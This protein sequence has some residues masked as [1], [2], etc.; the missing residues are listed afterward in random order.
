MDNVNTKH[1]YVCL[2]QHMHLEAIF[3]H[4]LR[5]RTQRLLLQL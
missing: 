3:P 2:I 4:T 1:S 5:D